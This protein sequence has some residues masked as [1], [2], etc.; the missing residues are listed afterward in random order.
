[1]RSCCRNVY[2]WWLPNSSVTPA[3]R[4]SPTRSPISASVRDSVAVTTAPR[5]AQNSAVATPVRANPTTSTRL[6]F[7]SIERLLPQFQ[8]GQCKQRK[9]QRDDPKPH[10]HLG[11]TPANQFKMMVDRRHAENPLAP[12]LERADL[13]DYRQRFDHKDPAYK[14]QQNLLLDHYRDDAECS[15][16]R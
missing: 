10:D 7:S 16:Q 5:A 13:K 12:K 4:S 1:M 14:K 9:N 2:S 11:F 15:T 6:F 3:A 8:R